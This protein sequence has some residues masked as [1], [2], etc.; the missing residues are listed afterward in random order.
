MASLPCWVH[1]DHDADVL[2]SWVRAGNGLGVVV[3]GEVG[4]GVADSGAGLGGGVGQQRPD[5][6]DAQV[7]RAETTRAALR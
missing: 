3:D 5:Q 4:A 1:G 7:V 2:P 6:R